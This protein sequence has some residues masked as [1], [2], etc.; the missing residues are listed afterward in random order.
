MVDNDIYD[1]KKKY[2]EITKKLL[3]GISNFLISKIIKNLKN[4]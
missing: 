3:T 4:Y 1:N 2:E